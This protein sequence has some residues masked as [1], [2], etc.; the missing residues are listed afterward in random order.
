[1]KNEFTIDGKKY[2]IK[3]FTFGDRNDMLNFTNTIDEKTGRVMV[4]IGRL[5]ELTLERGLIPV[6]TN[7]EPLTIEKIRAMNNEVAT[8]IYNQIQEAQKVPLVT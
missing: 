6:D 3:Q 5:R 2:K 7:V 4:M 1:M 8:K